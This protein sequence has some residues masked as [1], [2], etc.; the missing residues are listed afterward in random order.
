MFFS[1]CQASYL[2]IITPLAEVTISAPHEYMRI[3]YNS[4]SGRVFV[5]L[6]SLATVQ[7]IS[8]MQR[9]LPIMVL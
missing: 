7:F 3:F 8:G 9:E 6:I 4:Y 5:V 2:C 1:L